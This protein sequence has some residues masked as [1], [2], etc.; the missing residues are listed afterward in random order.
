MTRKHTVAIV[1]SCLILCFTMPMNI[2]ASDWDADSII[3]VLQ[4][5]FESGMEENPFEYNLTP[6]NDNTIRMTVSMSTTGMKK[7]E[8][9]DN[10]A[11]YKA[12][13]TWSDIADAWSSVS[14]SMANLSKSGYDMLVTLGYEDKS[15][16]VILV[17]D[18]D[19]EYSDVWFV[20]VNGNEVY[21]LFQ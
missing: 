8:V 11:L 17:D 15:F 16:S 3:S 18:K 10:M 9:L 12:S 7:D 2:L 14:A 13:G 5:A 20:A 6:Y 19:D 21:D 4:L 1:I